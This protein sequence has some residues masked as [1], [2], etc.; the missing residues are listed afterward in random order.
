[1]NVRTD[2]DWEEAD[3]V[4]EL[5]KPLGA[6][7]SPDGQCPDP[8]LLTAAQA[9]ILPDALAS[10]VADH[11]RHCRACQILARDLTDPELTAPTSLEADRIR[12]KV[13]QAG[14]SWSPASASRRVTGL[15]RG[16]PWL[17]WWR[18]VAV[19]ATLVA[20]VAAG[21]WIVG[22]R[23]GPPGVAAVQ[24]VPP[25]EP[26]R[27]ALEKPAVTM[28]LATVLAWRDESPGPQERYLTELGEAL[29]PYRA[30][31]FAEAARRLDVLSRNYPA[32]EVRY[33]RGVCHLFLER[34]DLA[35]ADLVQARQLARP[36]M[37][38]DATW[39]LAVAYERAGQ[40]EAAV[41]ELRTLCGGQ[42]E[43]QA[44]ACE[45]LTGLAPNGR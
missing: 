22:E 5:E 30:D 16:V 40:R 24:P 15:A 14:G 41:R 9:G 17:R 28:P 45:A 44:K 20:A 2:D 4:K 8:A 18:P 34:Y 3:S 38:Q 1:M 33:F 26:L 11:V 27:L 23:P 10:G 25:P 21:W 6:L 39:Y 7:R 42:G 43:R 31:D 32:A 12:A 36:A 35:I 19:A 29:T 37:A 13:F